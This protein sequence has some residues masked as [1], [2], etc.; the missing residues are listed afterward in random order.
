MNPPVVVAEIGCNHQGSMKMA[1]ESIGAAAKAGAS[2]AKFQKRDNHLH[3]TRNPDWSKPH[4]NPSQAFGPTYYEH[5]R[6]LEFDLLQHK[7]LKQACESHG[8]GY[9]C[10]A[11]DIPS[12]RTIITLE[13]SYIK[14]PSASNG[15]LELIQVLLTEYTG[16][17]HVSLG[18]ATNEERR[19]LIGIAKLHAGR[20][21]LYHCTSGY[22][23]PFGELNL[24][25][26]P[27]LAVGG[28]EPGYSGHHVGIAIDIAAYSKG[29][30]WIER[31]F[32]LDR[33]LKGTDQALSLEPPEMS[34][35]VFDLKRVHAA[36]TERMGITNVEEKQ[37]EKLRWRE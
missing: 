37:R 13:P 36:S 15:H 10:S 7:E 4:P 8:I 25:E 29:A 14:V 5:R 6:A 35:L 22:P 9:A 19:E 34:Q 28:L 32:T 20:V 18:M 21:R 26:I 2:F 1:I 17:V 33:T 24:D 3:L 30:T 31:H 12:A 27:T 23:V 11:W 16:E